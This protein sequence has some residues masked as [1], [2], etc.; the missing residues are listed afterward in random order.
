MSERVVTALA[1]IGFPGR[2]QTLTSF[3]AYFRD[4][5][6]SGI[7][8]VFRLKAFR[9]SSSLHIFLFGKGWIC[10]NVQ[11]L[12]NFLFKNLEELTKPVR[13]QITLKNMIYLNLLF[14]IIF[15]SS[16]PACHNPIADLDETEWNDL[17]RY[18]HSSDLYVM[19]HKVPR[20]SGGRRLT[21]ACRESPPPALSGPCMVAPGPGV[22]FQKWLHVI[23]FLDLLTRML[24]HI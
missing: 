21:A 14:I 13:R 3:C 17:Q 7:Q 23:L 4:T 8:S 11:F 18:L 10:G 5:Q 19:C 16:Y 24:L 22:D 20:P 1:R 15:F 9:Q 2:G 6:T 12:T